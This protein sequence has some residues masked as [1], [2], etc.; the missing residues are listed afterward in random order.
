MFRGPEN[1]LPANWKHLPIG[2]HGRASSLLASGTPVRRP[3]GQRR[4]GEESPV[5]APSARLDFELELAAVIG[6]GNELGRP[7]PVSEAW[8]HI[9]G[10]VL[11]NDWSARDIQQWEYVPLGPFLGKNFATSISPW[12]VTA[13]ALA[14]F[15]CAGPAQEVPVLPY[16]QDP[17][18]SALDI[19]L[20]VSLDLPGF[21]P[22]R[23]CR[24]NARHLY[25][26]FAQQ[27]AHHSCGGCN[28]RTGDLLASGTISGPEPGSYGSLLELAWRGSRPL[29]MPD[30]STRSFLEDG[31]TV[32][33]RGYA[34]QGGLRV[35]FGE[36]IGEV[37]PAWPDYPPRR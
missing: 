8:D 20:E 26:S 13:E 19:E 3:W 10:F 22:Q 29:P 16:L 25:W 23:V 33:M 11:L 35:G 9:F 4:P 2:Y 7:I 27:I 5:F 24:S 28:L 36:L 37:L 12:V 6:T 1:A 31:D 14:P 17:D 21:P 15:R 32:V 30:G 34:L 18:P